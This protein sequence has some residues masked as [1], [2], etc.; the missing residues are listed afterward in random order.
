M[1]DLG[2]LALLDQALHA[3]Y[4][5]LAMTRL[6]LRRSQFSIASRAF[7]VIRPS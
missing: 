6:D 5:L 1:G 7:V 4:Q 3:T 2:H